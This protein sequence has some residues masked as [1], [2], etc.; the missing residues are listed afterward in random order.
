[1]PLEK[2]YP[3]RINVPSTVKMKARVAKLAEQTDFKMAQIARKCLEVGLAHYEQIQEMGG[4]EIQI[5][6]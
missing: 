2:I 1:M 6:Q 4:T 3:E 5:D